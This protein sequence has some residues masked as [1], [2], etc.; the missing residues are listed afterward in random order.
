GLAGPGMRGTID[1]AAEAAGAG[2]LCCAA[3]AT[4]V[5]VTPAAARPA[6]ARFAISLPRRG[7]IRSLIS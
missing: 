7:G 1:P 3:A 4:A 5:T 6:A 2:A